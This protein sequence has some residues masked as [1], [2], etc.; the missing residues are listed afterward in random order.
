MAQS[1][2]LLS[3]YNGGK[4]LKQQLDSLENQTDQKWDLIVRDDGS[5]DDTLAILKKYQDKTAHKVI[6]ME[7]HLKY[8]AAG[9]FLALLEA[10]VELNYD[11]LFFCDQD[12]VWKPFKL[13]TSIKKIN[14]VAAEN[15][16]ESVLVHSDLEIVDEHLKTIYPS[17]WLASG[18]NPRN[19]KINNYLVENN[20][21][22][23]TLAL[24]KQAADLIVRIS[25]AANKKKLVMHDWWSALIVSAFGR[26][27]FIQET[28]VLYRQHSKNTIGLNKKN[29]ISMLTK[30]YVKDKNFTLNNA[31]NQAQEIRK[32]LD[33]CRF[34]NEE[35]EQLIIGY[36]TILNQP[37]V[38]RLRFLNKYH[39]RKTGAV[40]NLGFIL[41][42]LLKRRR[43]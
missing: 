20:V 26:V 15:N 41:L 5:E 27:A 24:N 3:T 42:M 8:G 22:G 39:L 32:Y 14:E 21:T 6:F 17:M 18:T 40:K 34:E 35:A 11:Y 23:C 19:N 25:R 9:S 38:K 1:A 28:L 29:L 4:Y 43:K 12:D 10:A 36:S 7:D 2:I 37:P 33:E 31:V 30:K 13:E 16:Q